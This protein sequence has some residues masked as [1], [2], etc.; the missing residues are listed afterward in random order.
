[1]GLQSPLNVT[2]PNLTDFLLYMIDGGKHIPETLESIKSCVCVTLRLATGVDFS[3]NP[4]L[5]AVMQ[6]FHKECPRAT[7]QLPD[8]NLV[9]VLDALM[10]SPF[11][12]LSQASLKHLTYK[13]VFLVAMSCS[14]RISELHALDFRKLQHSPDWSSVWLSPHAMFLAKNQKSR[15]SSYERQFKLTNLV[16]FVGSQEPDRLLCPVRALKYYLSRTKSFRG[17]KKCLF[18]SLQPNRKADITKQS[19]NIWIRNTIRLAYALHGHQGDPL[20]RATNHEIRSV[21]SSLAFEKSLSL[22]SVLKACCWKNNNTFTS[23]YLKDV[24]VLANDL[25]RFSP[26]VVASSVISKVIIFH[27]IVSFHYHIP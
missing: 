16:Q 2:V 12:P 13:T 15:K 5:T 6:K 20:G 27:Y 14:C 18:I 23:Y 17:T 19:I 4:E 3:H 7:F 24:T 9:Y 11:E 22:S 25:M 26:L 8:W 21:C 1:M 10:K